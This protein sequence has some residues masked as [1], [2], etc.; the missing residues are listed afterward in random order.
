MAHTRIGCAAIPTVMKVALVS[1][2]IILLVTPAAAETPHDRVRKIDNA[3]TAAKRR[4]NPLPASAADGARL[5]AQLDALAVSA[6]A[7]LT[8]DLRVV[9]IYNDVLADANKLPALANALRL[10][11]QCR[12]GIRAGRAA[13]ARGEIIDFDQVRG[14]CAAYENAKANTPLSMLSYQQAENELAA[15]HSRALEKRGV[16]RS[17]GACGRTARRRASVDGLR[18]GSA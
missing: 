1:V 15:L 13:V 11:Y 4:V 6:K 8:S 10:A 16:S 2:W 3:I 7:A 12:D 14:A 18:V 17:E 9:E 5:A